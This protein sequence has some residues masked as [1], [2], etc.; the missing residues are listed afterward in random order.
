MKCLQF[1]LQITAEDYLQFYSGQAKSVSAVSVDGHRI[2]FPAEHLRQFVVAD[3]ISGYFEL[4]FDENNRF[5][6]ITKLRT[7]Y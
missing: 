1:R 3:G 4:C 6:K 5:K 2:E 7:S